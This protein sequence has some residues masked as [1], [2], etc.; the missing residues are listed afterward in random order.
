LTHTEFRSSVTQNL[1]AL[2]VDPASNFVGSK[3][4][5]VM[6]LMGTSMK[7]DQLVTELL[8]E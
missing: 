5:E 4:Y 3:M 8:R 2:L 7:T 6:T 1:N